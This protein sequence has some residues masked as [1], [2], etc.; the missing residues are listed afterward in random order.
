MS[1][2]S[3][4]NLTPLI[5][6]SSA[7][8]C[9][10]ASTILLLQ[11]LSSQTHPWDFVSQFGIGAIFGIFL[12]A[13]FVLFEYQRSPAK[14]LLLVV[15]STVAYL[16]AYMVTA[17]LYEHYPTILGPDPLAGLSSHGPGDVPLPIFFVGG[18]TGALLVLCAALL[19]FRPKASAA[20]L[21][22]SVLSGATVGG[23]LGVLGWSIH[24]TPNLAQTSVFFLHLVWQPGIALVLAVI[25]T[26]VT[27]RAALPQ[28]SDAVNHRP[29]LV[30]RIAF[31]FCVIGFLLWFVFVFFGG[32][33]RFGF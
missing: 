27:D 26:F 9:S 7:G 6:L 4:L 11:L 1:D 21:L 30:I 5:G 23:L 18:F 17:G 16:A 10:A 15:G 14:A 3:T 8:L 33:P 25:V 24:P 20:R 22:I 19:L 12:A 32:W 31:F 29:I 2:D 28:T 13:Y